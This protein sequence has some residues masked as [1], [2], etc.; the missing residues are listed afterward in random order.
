[1]ADYRGASFVVE[2]NPQDTVDLVLSPA[3]NNA[4]V[5][6][7]GMGLYKVLLAKNHKAKMLHL[8]KPSN[9]LQPKLPC[10]KWNATVNIKATGNEITTC[11]FEVNGEQCADD[12]DEGCAQN[13]QG[14]GSMIN[15]MTATSELT[16]LQAAMVLLLREGIVDDVYKVAWFGDEKF[17]TPEYSGFLDL[18]KMPAPEDQDKATKMLS[19]CQGWWA[20]LLARTTEIDPRRRVRLVDTND[21][22]PEGNATNPANILAFLERL[23]YTDS[24]ETLRY[25]GNG[26][27]TREGKV[28]LLQHELY[29]A[30][31][32]YMQAAGCQNDCRLIVDGTPVQGVY[33]FEGIPVIEVAEWSKFDAEF[34]GLD[35]TGRSRNQRAVFTALEN[36]CI[37]TDVD[38]IE[39]YPES[40]LMI[41]KSP[42][43]RDKGRYDMYAGYRFG[44]GIAHPELITIGIN[45]SDVFA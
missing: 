13:L 42:L 18:S 34:G 14:S 44:F 25:W 28:I 32:K 39:G 12:F 11:S 37:A 7:G 9:S 24:H 36:L 40:G 23:V 29:R 30:Y 45:S 16:A 20:E 31:I 22:T 5:L 15:D 38:S 2:L 41:E 43:L 19:H 4:N 17:G 35:A 27:A 6:L 3:I 1:M 10:N 33:T 21:G 26:T 8:R